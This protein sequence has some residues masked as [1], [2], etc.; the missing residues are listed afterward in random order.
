MS[1]PNQEFQPP[2]PPVVEAEPERQ[3]PA[4]LMW[5]AIALVVIGIVIVVLGITG[6]VTGGAGTGAAVCVLVVLFFA[7]SFI[8]LPY[9]KDA[10]PPLS[11]VETLTGIFYEPTSVFRNLRAHPR[12]LEAILLIGIVN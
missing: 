2:P 8:K 11:Q 5:A 3:R 6:I 12:W 10:P 1:D 7:F 9:V 4:N